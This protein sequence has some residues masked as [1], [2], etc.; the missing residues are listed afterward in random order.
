MRSDG[1]FPNRRGDSR[2]PNRSAR[3]D[4]PFADRQAAPALPI[5]PDNAV[6]GLTAKE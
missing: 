2:T 4:S 3:A 6:P 1:L 5:L